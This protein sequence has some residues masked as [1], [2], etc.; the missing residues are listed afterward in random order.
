VKRRYF[1]SIFYFIIIGFFTEGCGPRAYFHKADD[2]IAEVFAEEIIPVGTGVRAR[3]IQLERI[4]VG[5]P[6][7]TPIGTIGSGPVCASSK[8]LVWREPSTA[9]S[10]EDFNEVLGLELE[11]A[12]YSVVGSSGGLVDNASTWKAELLVSGLVKDL[13]ANICY[14]LTESLAR[15][16]AKGEAYVSMAW[17]VYS[18]PE[19]KVVYEAWTVGSSVVEEPRTS[20]P[21]H[22]ILD[23]F[24]MATQNLLADRGFYEVVIRSEPKSPEPTSS[25]TVDG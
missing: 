18:R 25:K 14:P 7:G 20:V 17:Q 24:A 3:P 13:K 19:K 4:V 8:D 11:K 15:E 5:L 9:L 16:D 6:G 21:A 1:R 22:L 2:I 10:P 23:A 12:N